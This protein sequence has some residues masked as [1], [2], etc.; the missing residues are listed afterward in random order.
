MA[1]ISFINV[2]NDGVLFY[3]LDKVAYLVKTATEFAIT[4]VD[5]E[6]AT[7]AASSYDEFSKLYKA[8]YTAAGVHRKGN[9][10]ISLT[11]KATVVGGST[12][13]PPSGDNLLNIS[14]LNVNTSDGFIRV[15]AQ[16]VLSITNS[17]EELFVNLSNGEYLNS[18]FATTKE[19]EA[20]VV[21]YGKALERAKRVV[22]GTSV[23]PEISA[24]AISHNLGVDAYTN[25]LANSSFQGGAGSV[26]GADWTPPTSWTNAFWPPDEAIYNAGAEASIYFEVALN[27]GYIIQT[28]DT[29]ALVGQRINMSVYCDDVQEASAQRICHI[30]GNAIEI[31][32][33]PPANSAGRYF[34]IYEITGTSIQI[35]VGAGTTAN[36]NQ[37]TT[38]SR[39]QLTIGEPLRPYKS[40]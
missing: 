3:D 1:K 34:G 7:F 40:T 16:Q 27:R 38:L 13:E 23:T 39:P 9:R 32:G 6:S 24:Q 11:N 28:I 37:K 15:N 20:A 35:R 17:A 4:T 8:Y 30:T 21:T 18:T 26:S 10:L 22:V 19:A 33:V 25:L 36:S 29:T 31:Q 14:F 2:A 12:A 5:G